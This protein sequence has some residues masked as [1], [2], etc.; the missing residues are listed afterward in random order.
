MKE[1]SALHFTKYQDNYN[2]QYS[3]MCCYSS[4]A[5]EL[6]GCSRQNTDKKAPNVDISVMGS[7]WYLG[8]TN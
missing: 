1:C 8:I 7:G 6:R 4:A 3:W 5:L 2:N